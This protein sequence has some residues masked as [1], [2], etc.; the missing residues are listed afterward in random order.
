M[1]ITDA[2]DRLTWSD[3]YGL[4][5]T[6]ARQERHHSRLFGWIHSAMFAALAENELPEFRPVAWH[7]T[8]IV[9]A[10]DCI[11]GLTQVFAGAVEWHRVRDFFAAV[12]DV[13]LVE[14]KERRLSR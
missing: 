2:V 13:L 10:L 1:A 4:A 11:A 6:A 9:P 3:C 14:F 12:A 8:E 7:S 5:H